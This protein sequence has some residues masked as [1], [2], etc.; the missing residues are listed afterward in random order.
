VKLLLDSNAYLWAIL[1]PSEL[2]P[3]ARRA[4]EDTDN[5]RFVSVA[6]LWELTIKA[7]I[8]KLDLPDDFMEGVEHLEASLLPL[9]V[10][11]MKKLRTLP[12]HHRD[13]FDRLLVAQALSEQLTIVTRDRR[14]DAYGVSILA[15]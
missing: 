12:L 10:P 8:G 15:A 13:P 4:L 7:S 14:F 2:A 3:S 6:S 11:H 9:A 1:R 5:Q